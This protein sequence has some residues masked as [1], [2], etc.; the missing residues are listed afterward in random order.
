MG[1]LFAVRVFA[2]GPFF[3]TSN[4]TTSLTNA[5]TYGKEAVE[6]ALHFL[7]EF[8]D[9]VRTELE[10]KVEDCLSIWRRGLEIQWKVSLPVIVLGLVTP[11]RL[12]TESIPSTHQTHFVGERQDPHADNEPSQDVGFP[13][14]FG[15]TRIVKSLSLRRSAR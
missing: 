14:L 5:Q 12:R 1:F 9:L 8:S 6:T 11:Q 7:F 13:S 4:S 15:P 3:R 10:F 2:P